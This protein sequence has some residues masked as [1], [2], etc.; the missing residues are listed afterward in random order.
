[1]KYLSTYKLNYQIF[2]IPFYKKNKF[3]KFENSK[4]E[5]ALNFQLYDANKVFITGSYACFTE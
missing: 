5:K 1:M 2:M 3:N 4:N